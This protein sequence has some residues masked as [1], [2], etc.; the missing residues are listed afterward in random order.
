MIADLGR[1]WNWKAA[2]LSSISRGL[3]FFAT[4]VPVGL[5]A[6]VRAMLT[7]LAF[8]AV[9]SGL[10]GALTQ[11][12]RLV[13]PTWAGATIALLVLPA[14]G[15]SAEY[16]VHSLAGTPRLAT[17][18]ILSVTFTSVTTLFNLFAM[19]RGVLIVGPGQQP[20]RTD[21]A[22]LPRLLAAFGHE[23]WRAACG[24]LRLVRSCWVFRR[25]YS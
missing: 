11:R 10:L 16:I 3:L 17:S 23:A 1:A 18:I 7:E 25:L 15:H 12:L 22:M 14:L 21:L 6:G 9:A 2:V 24:V 13:Q 5:D 20:L 8:R 4:N 19:R